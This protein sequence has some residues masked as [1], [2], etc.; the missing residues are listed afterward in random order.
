MHEGNNISLVLKM[1][2]QDQSRYAED[3]KE[4]RKLQDKIDQLVAQN[5]LEYLNR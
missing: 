3:S 4:W 5:Y 1:L 2:R